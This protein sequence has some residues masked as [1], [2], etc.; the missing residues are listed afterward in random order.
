VAGRLSDAAA[1]ILIPADRTTLA[2]NRTFVGSAS[3]CS[4]SSS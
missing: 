3:C 2:S 4:D 1:V